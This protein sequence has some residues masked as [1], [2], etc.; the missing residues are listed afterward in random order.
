MI[1]P[2]PRGIS[3]VGLDQAFESEERRKSS[4]LLE[5]RLLREQGNE[6][7]AALRFAKA[8]GIEEQ[9]SEL[10]IEHGLME[11][12]WVHRFSAA[13]CWAAAGNF[14]DALTACDELLRQADLPERLRR[15]VSDYSE[16]IRTRRAEWYAALEPEN[17]ALEAA[18]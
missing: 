5:A 2:A 10:C 9:L 4:L 7:A 18:R 3:R 14:H 1:S 11:K 17:A 13:S 16:T 6:D 8:A 15:S 12:S